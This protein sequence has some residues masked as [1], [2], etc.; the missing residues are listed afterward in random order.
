MRVFSANETY[1]VL[2]NKW[3]SKKQFQ[4]SFVQSFLP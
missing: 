4:L 3:K 1:T 2:K